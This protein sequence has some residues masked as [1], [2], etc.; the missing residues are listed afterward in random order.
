M[1]DGSFKNTLNEHKKKKNDIWLSTSKKE[2]MSYI[3]RYDQE[4]PEIPE[5]KKDIRSYIST[6]PLDPNPTRYLAFFPTPSL[7]PNIENPYSL[8]TGGRGRSP[9]FFVK[10]LNHNFA[11]IIQKNYEIYNKWVGKSYLT[12]SLCYDSKNIAKILWIREKT[13]G[14]RTFSWGG[15]P[16]S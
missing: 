15:G 9:N 13:V 10:F 11:G 5:S 4:H 1:V 3:P 2:M 7:K 12:I 8:G 14:F 16:E 6:L